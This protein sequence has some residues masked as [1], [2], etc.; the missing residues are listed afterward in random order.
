MEQDFKT[1]YMDFTIADKFGI[2]AIKDTYSRA[3]KE[4]KN[5]YKY[6]TLLVLNLKHKI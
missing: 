6:L 1:F 4:W 5:D 2:E 3:F